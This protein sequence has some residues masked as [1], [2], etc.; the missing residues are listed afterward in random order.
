MIT[1][2][3]FTPLPLP[4][5]PVFSALG[6]LASNPSGA[7]T[8]MLDGLVR[9]Q[10][11]GYRITVGGDATVH[12]LNHAT[13]EQYLAW[14]PPMFAMDGSAPFD[15]WGTTTLQLEDGTKLTI[16]TSPWA[17]DP[18]VTISSK[19]TISNHDYGVE[20]LGMGGMGGMDGNSAHGLRFVETERYGWLLDAAVGDGN[21]LF[22]NAAGAGFIGNEAGGPW[23]QVDQ[24]YIDA[25]DLARLGP[26]AGERGK[27]LLS[28]SS[29][30]AVTFVGAYRIPLLQHNINELDCNR[31][32]PP[33]RSEEAGERSPCA[34]RLARVDEGVAW[35]AR[36]AGV[37][38][39]WGAPG[40]APHAC[41]R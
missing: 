15:F 35:F 34:L 32:P 37:H 4:F 36:R 25:T 33:R 5:D 23:Q 27:A 38:P 17:D 11:N 8:D 6:M 12:I 1:N 40:W 7:R 21:T 26:L 16:T 20:V 29:L 18:L 39:S 9:F 28:T 24:A 31:E 14:N 2:S 41:R 22:E 13:T 3:A 30:L 10:N 19:V